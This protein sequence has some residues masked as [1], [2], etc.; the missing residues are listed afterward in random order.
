VKRQLRFPV[1]YL[2]FNDRV[3]VNTYFF[4]TGTFESLKAMGLTADESV[5]KRFTFWMDEGTPD[6]V[7]AE[8]VVEMDPR[9]KHVAVLD[10]DVGFYT[11]AGLESAAVKPNT[12]FE[13]TRDR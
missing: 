2:D 4:C 10:T 9:W 12:S 3:R 7:I 1:V 11:R 6:D 8:G 13:R 5:G